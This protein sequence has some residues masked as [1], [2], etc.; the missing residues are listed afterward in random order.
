MD[1]LGVSLFQKTFKRWLGLGICPWSFDGSEKDMVIE[2][3]MK[4]AD[5][6]GVDTDLFYVDSMLIFDDNQID[7]GKR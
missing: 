2:N 1:D 4:N 5:L 3:T 6:M 7:S